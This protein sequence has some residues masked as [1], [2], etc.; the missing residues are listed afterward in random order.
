MILIKEIGRGLVYL[1]SLIYHIGGNFR[2]QGH[3][4]IM[5]QKIL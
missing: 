4:K 3:N 5:R 2:I 1:D